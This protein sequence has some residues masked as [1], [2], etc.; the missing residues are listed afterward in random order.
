MVANELAH[1]WRELVGDSPAATA[2]GAEL[3]RR[4]A[5]PHRRYHTQEHLAACLDAVDALADE[6]DGPTA[7]RLAVWFHD[8]VYDRRPGDD[9]EA[10][11]ALAED[12]LPAL[13]I[14]PP[15][16]AEVARLVRLTVS[17]RPGPDDR[18]G[19]VVCDAD[20]SVLGGTPESYATYASQIR[21]E[22]ADI[23]ED[24]FRAGRR[25]V[26]ED[27]ASRNPLF[28]TRTARDRWEDRARRNVATELAL[29][30]VA[31]FFD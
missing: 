4:W 2:L 26:L 18:N 13:G 23:D 28:R 16:V 8:A 21:E 25:Q 1:R 14:A 15:L 12:R 17:H 27:L 10:S 3:L 19:A 22:Y 29:L 9:E 31:G 20:L 7:V 5:E 30:R 11:A 24:T 6:A